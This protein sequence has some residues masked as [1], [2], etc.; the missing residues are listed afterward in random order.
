MLATI[1][2]V[3]RPIQIGA[4]VGR[5]TV[6]GIA[7]TVRKVPNSRLA[8]VDMLKPEIGLVQSTWSE[9]RKYYSIKDKKIVEFLRE[10]KPIPEEFRQ[11]PP[12]EIVLDMWQDMKKRLD[13]IEKKLNSISK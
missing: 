7:D 10:R 12:H 9:G 3:A 6:T 5:I 1:V 11:K 13:R 8:A 2:I 4:S